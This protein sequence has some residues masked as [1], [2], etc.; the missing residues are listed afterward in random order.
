MATSSQPLQPPVDKL[1]SDSV[2]AD[3]PTLIG[4]DDK[5][6]GVAVAVEEKRDIAFDDDEYP[7]G[8]RGWLVLFGVSDQ[9]SRSSLC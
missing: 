9:P 1:D 6:Q 7:E 3:A 5:E 2:E 4:G 8:G